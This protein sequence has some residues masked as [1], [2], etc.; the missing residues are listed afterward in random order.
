MKPVLAREDH[1]GSITENNL[2]IEQNRITILEYIDNKL[3]YWS[4]NEF[5]VPL[6]INDSIFRGSIVFFQNGWFL[7]K[8]IQAGNEKIVGLLRIRTEYNFENDII[9]SGFEED[10]KI[11]ECRIQY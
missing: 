11:P 9:K 6:F 5:D 7:A 4:D 2:L 3:V 10:F 1:H 8:T